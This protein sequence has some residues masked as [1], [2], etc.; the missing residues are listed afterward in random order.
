MYPKTQKRHGTRVVAQ[1]KEAA[2]QRPSDAALWELLGDLLASLEP[3][4]GCWA[5]RRAVLWRCAVA[6]CCAAGAALWI[7]VLHRSP[8]THTRARAR[9]LAGALKAYDTAIGIR[10]KEAAQDAAPALPV[11]L[12]NNAA[13]LHLRAGS[14][15][16][17]YDLM[18]QAVAA[19]AGAPPSELNPLAQVGI[20]LQAAN[21]AGL[22]G[23]R[24]GGSGSSR[25]GA[26]SSR[27]FKALP[28]CWFHTHTA[29]CLLHLPSN[30]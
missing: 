6:L 9:T 24:V 12:L 25:L 18:A 21:T 7:S 5:L 30:R 3:A 28:L 23:G 15:Q 10:R 14:S 2:A 22:G 19:A 20:F 11:R 8:S 27:R 1:F 4:G 13:V 16:L 29:A 17:A 26:C